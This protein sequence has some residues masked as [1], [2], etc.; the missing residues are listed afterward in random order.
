MDH[1]GDGLD[2]LLGEAD[3]RLVE[4]DRLD[5]PDPLPRD[6]DRLLGCEALARG[7]RL[8]E[9]RRKAL[10]AQVPLIEE[11]LRRLDHRGHDPRLADHTAGGADG[12]AARAPCD[13]AYLESELRGARERITALVH[14]RRPSM[15]RLAAPR[16]AVT[17]D[18]EG[19][20]NHAEREP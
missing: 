4:Q 10:R 16:D 3:Q 2:R 19:A 14:R 20:E 15:S 1:G 13:L 12:T 11:L 7:P 5:R 8:G 9:H 6:L 18:P 17:L